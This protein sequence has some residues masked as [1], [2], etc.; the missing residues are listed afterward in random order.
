M[1]F[2]AR[3]LSAGRLIVRRS[4]RLNPDDPEF[5]L[6]RI[7]Q[8]ESREIECQFHFNFII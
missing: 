2:C 1:N 3:D 5:I 7:L 4:G 8:T 6:E